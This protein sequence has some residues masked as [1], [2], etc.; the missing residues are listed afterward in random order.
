MTETAFLTPEKLQKYT[1]GK[2]I[3]NEEVNLRFTGV[4]Y[5]QYIK[6]NIYFPVNPK[7]RDIESFRKYVREGIKAIVIDDAAMADKIDIPVLLVDNV[8]NAFRDTA[9]KVRQEANPKTILITGTEGKTGTKLQLHHILKNQTNVHAVLNSQNNLKSVYR[10]LADIGES[11]DVEI[12][13][14]GCGANTNLNRTRG[15]AVNPDI[16]FFTQIGLAHMDFHKT[17]SKLLENKAAVVAGLR[18]DGICIV[19]ST[20]ECFDEFID[21]IRNEKK[22]LKILTYGTN[23]SDDAQVLDRKYIEDR[24]SW[25]IKARIEDEELEFDHPVFH[26]YIPV[27]SVGMLLVAKKL[28]FNVKKTA[29]QFFD[30][31]PFETMGQI[32]EIRRS[33]DSF[34]FYNQSR[35]G[36]GINSVV[37]SFLDLKNFRYSGKVIA[38]LGS[39][40]IKESEKDTYD[41]HKS[42]ADLIN[43]SDISRL[44]TTG[45]HMEIV[46]NNLDDRAVLVKH[47]EDYG[48]LFD[49]IM[50]EIEDGDLL[51]IKG[52]ASLGLTNIAKKILLHKDTCHNYRIDKGLITL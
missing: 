4:S 10:T 23:M 1:G 27:M 41:L 12:T 43:S 34:L 2:W 48:E 24:R 31:Q 19:N 13:E 5:D 21:K 45:V 11:D 15:R 30:F 37:S 50:N 39:M 42:T 47:S 6:G 26:Q 33:E 44:Y 18:D 22:D 28:G 20:I 49:D 14:V 9:L 36:G 16:C 46:K 7:K 35:R 25:K 17:L 32:L 52:H 51:F 8:Y 29:K 40:S 38:L 3:N